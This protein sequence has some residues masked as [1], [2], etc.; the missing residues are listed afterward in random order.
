M[1]EQQF[2]PQA[3]LSRAGELMRYARQSE[4][5][6]VIVGGIAGGIAGA[7]MAV[8]IAGR[9]ASAS[10]KEI[11]KEAESVEKKSEG[12]SIREVVQLATIAATLIRQAQD[13]Y[14]ERQRTNA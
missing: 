13:W 10:R 8:L 1:E 11:A 14:Q 2:D 7:V 5:Y 3:V 9:V 6:P 4:A 12:W